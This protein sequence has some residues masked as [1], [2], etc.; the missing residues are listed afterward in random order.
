M[1]FIETWMDLE[2]IILGEISQ[3]EKYKDGDIINQISEWLDNIEDAGELDGAEEY[4]ESAF[5]EGLI[6]DVGYEELLNKVTSRLQLSEDDDESEDDTIEDSDLETDLKSKILK[7]VP[8]VGKVIE[9]KQEEKKIEKVL[10]EAENELSNRFVPYLKSKEK[11]AVEKGKKH[12]KLWKK[13]TGF[14][15]TFGSKVMEFIRNNS[16]WLLPLAI[17]LLVIFV[18]IPIIVA[19]A[20]WPIKWLLWPDDDSAGPG[21]SGGG[22]S[23]AFGVTG[24]DF[25]GVRTIYT[26]DEKARVGLL[27]EYSTI[28]DN[29]IEQTLT[30]EKLKTITTG[31]GEDEV[32]KTYKVSVVVDLTIPQ[33]EVEGE[34]PTDFDYS[35]FE[36][37]SFKNTYTEYYALLNLVAEKVYIHDNPT[38]NIPTT[39]V[40]KL[41]GIKYF[42][43]DAVVS[44]EIKTL[45][46]NKLL[47]LYDVEVF[48]QT[49]NKVEVAEV[50]TEL[51]NQLKTELE[52]EINVKVSEVLSP[53]TAR[54]EKLFVKDFILSDNEDMM[55]GITEE[56][57]VCWI[58]MPKTA[59]EFEQVS[60][61]IKHNNIENFNI[62]L[63]NNGNEITLKK[64]D[65]DFGD[66]N[67]SIYT[68]FA[69]NLN[70]DVAV[71][72]NL[73]T[74]DLEALKDG[75]SLSKIINN[76]NLN[77]DKYLA[78]NKD[79]VY[80][81]AKSGMYVEF[82][83]LEKF[84][85]SEVETNWSARSN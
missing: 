14:L 25:Y 65:A 71:F 16:T 53:Y 52:N 74:S 44:E 58:F 51:K 39:L 78:L 42:G 50:K 36:E 34:E 33:T 56:N 67:V 80:T 46:Y 60:F 66:E 21:G 62:K 26:D 17:I 47:A 12:P 19:V 6:D 69:K 41:D 31:S 38:G 27:E 64:D 84:Y 79:G 23:A 7:K 54:T 72:E 5:R 59:V 49:E 76:S 22:G 32:S 20:L 3:T 68:Y 40:E 29:S 10:E 37:D 18:G 85:C 83:S 82:E 70:E 9:Y 63:F 4:I 35:T 28:I 77:N 1:L 43:L 8:G 73:D 30:V 57:Y 15:K 61:Y 45:T 81:F 48:N 13:I 55:N 11:D 75:V 24:D 2:I